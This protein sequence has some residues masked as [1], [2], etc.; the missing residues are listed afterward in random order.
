MP[1]G[2]LHAGTFMNATNL[3]LHQNVCQPASIYTGIFRGK[4]N[5]M[6]E[7][8]TRAMGE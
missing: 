1:H 5:T 4:D 2:K 3:R 8:T 7:T 6:P